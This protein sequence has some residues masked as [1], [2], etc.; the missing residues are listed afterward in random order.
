[1]EHL[2]GYQLGILGCEYAAISGPAQREMKYTNLD[3]SPTGGFE[4]PC[5]PSSTMT[6]PE[7]IGHLAPLHCSGPR[8]HGAVM[9]KSG[10]LLQKH[11]HRKEGC[12]ILRLA[13]RYNKYSIVLGY[14]PAGKGWVNVRRNR[15]RSCCR[16]Q[17]SSH[18]PIFA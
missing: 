8:L 18:Q 11:E 12:R 10:N 7:R 13:S 2:D 14:L 1:M 5:F 6:F 16:R 15:E 17:V 9:R 4:D 3:W